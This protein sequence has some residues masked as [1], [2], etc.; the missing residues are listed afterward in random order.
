M[1]FMSSL[2]GEIKRKKAT[3]HLKIPRCSDIKRRET[4]VSSL[5]REKATGSCRKPKIP[6]LSERKRQTL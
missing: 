4:E 1:L 3:E 5:Q 6:G 2:L